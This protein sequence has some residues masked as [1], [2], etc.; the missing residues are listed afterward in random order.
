M[1][2]F[3]DILRLKAPS[4]FNESQLTASLS[5]R[6]TPVPPSNLIISS[7]QSSSIG[8]FVLPGGDSVSGGPG[9]STLLAREEEPALDLDWDLGL[10][11]DADGNLQEGP[12]SGAE[13][14][15]TP[16]RPFMPNDGNASARVREEH[17]VWQA[18]VALPV[19][20]CQPNIFDAY[21]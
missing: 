8:G 5:F 20:S 13:P 11:F 12:A 17:A 14:Q 16:V 2:L 21:D 10:N 9:P 3:E 6:G 19:K 15:Q 18:G 7:S 4:T 1:P